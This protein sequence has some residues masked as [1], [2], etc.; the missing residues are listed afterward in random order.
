VALRVLVEDSSLVISWNS[1]ESITL[2][3]DPVLQFWPF[4]SSKAT[5]SVKKCDEERLKR[6]S[7]DLQCGVVVVAAAAMSVA[8]LLLPLTVNWTNG[9]ALFWHGRLSCH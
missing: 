7:G 8:V 5:T 2:Q 1:L 6:R 3:G 4:A 9:D